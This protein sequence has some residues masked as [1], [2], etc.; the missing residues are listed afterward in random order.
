M[1]EKYRQVRVLGRGASGHVWLADGPQG[2]VAL[3]V[4]HQPGQLRR[5]IT[6]LRRVH[7]P[8][9]ARLL[10]ADPDGDWLAMEYASRGTAAEWAP[11][12]PLGTLV[13]FTARAAE[14][15]AA[16]HAAGLVHGD[17]KPG[18]VLVA[19][20]HTPRLIDLGSATVDRAVG[21][22]A[23]TPGYAAPE[24]LR[25]AAA[26]IATDL[27]GL[28][29]LLYTLLTNR[30]PF[31]NSGRGDAPPDPNTTL[32]APLTTLPEPVSSTRPGLPGGLDD[33]VL[34]LMAHHAEAR[35]ASA[36]LVAIE[37]RSSLLSASRP[38]LVGMDRERDQLRRAL[39]DTLGGGR[40]MV[41]LHGPAGSGRGALIR[42]LTRS[43]QRERLRVLPP[44][45][46]DAVLGE[47]AGGEPFLLAL[48]AGA[49]GS[50][51]M[52]LRLL[53]APAAG[54]ILVRSDRPMP[55][56][57]RRGARHLSM[58][59]LTLDDI[60]LI[61]ESCGHAR[62]RRETVLRQSSGLPAAIQW[63]LNPVPTPSLPP[64]AQKVM[65]Y[66]RAGTLTVPSLS[67]R[68]DMPEHQVLDIVEPMIDRGLVAAS[69]DGVW[70]SVP[71]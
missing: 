53:S 57:T 51:A 12:H 61:L 22:T 35:P 38:P 7:H 23:A 5:E 70:L 65:E 32:W 26:S 33:L 48:D 2:R 67:Q 13:E 8:S 50:D 55:A 6:A 58:S 54:L 71:R 37:L 29:A 31:A 4:A 19:E 47:P 52:L 63:I 66:L 68:L 21:A 43:A 10:D 18:N 41:V 1:S 56:L 9:V 39:V 15:L 24:R 3:K 45:S 36:S 60:A 27:W 42:E 20:D 17:V 69:I 25:S 28:G 40:S 14:G 44:G 34:H 62:H 11:G 30:A 46:E 16:L 49:T 59:V 64:M